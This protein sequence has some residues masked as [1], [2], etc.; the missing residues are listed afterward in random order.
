[1]DVKEVLTERI[2][3]D[4]RA[5][6][7]RTVIGNRIGFLESGLFVP[8]QVEHEIT[9]KKSQIKAYKDC[10]NILKKEFFE[11]QLPYD[12]TL[13]TKLHEIKETIVNKIYPIDDRM[14]GSGEYLH[15]QM[16]NHKKAGEIADIIEG[17]CYQMFN[18][19]YEYAIEQ[20]KKE[21]E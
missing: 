7:M 16:V 8:P 5:E 6:Q 9:D 21:N 4:F 19:G 10:L 1:M 3:N 20:N 13:E 18:Q 2:Q 14:K 11:L 12:L 15:K 17:L